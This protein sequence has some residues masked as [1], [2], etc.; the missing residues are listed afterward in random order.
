MALGDDG[1]LQ[2]IRAEKNYR[3]ERD[4]LKLDIGN[5]PKRPSRKIKIHK[6]W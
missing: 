1:E 6:T 5:S 2:V 3:E 4:N